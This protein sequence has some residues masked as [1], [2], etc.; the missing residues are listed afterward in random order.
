MSLIRSERADDI[1]VLQLA[2]GRA[3]A[4]N[5]ELVNALHDACEQIT[6]LLPVWDGVN[7]GAAQDRVGRLVEEKQAEIAARIAELEQFAA[8]LD[9]VRASLEAEPALGPKTVFPLPEG[10]VSEAMRVPGFRGSKAVRFQPLGASMPH[11]R[12]FRVS[13][14]K[15]VATPRPA[16]SLRV[17]RRLV[18]RLAITEEKSARAVIWS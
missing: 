13:T 18:T 8:Q 12:L 7:C 17:S 3:N 16:A 10:N 6:S 1:L 14:M 11:Q 5:E 2:R 4:L 9:D 15:A